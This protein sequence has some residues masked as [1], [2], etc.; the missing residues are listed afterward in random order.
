MST[1]TLRKRISLVAVTALTAGV[2]SVVVAPAANANIYNS[3]NAVATV[4]ALNVATV[5]S[6]GNLT[7]AVV[8]AADAA[9]SSG[10]K[11]HAL[12]YKDASSTTAQTATVLAGGT[13]VLYTKSHATVA[14]GVGFTATGGSFGTTVYDNSQ[15]TAT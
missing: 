14:T 6:S 15:A 9:S 11:S 4:S 8:I 5:S 3:T 13:L 7:G 2:L 10:Y 12:L 1:K